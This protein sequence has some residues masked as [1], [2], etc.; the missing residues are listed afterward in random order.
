MLISSSEIQVVTG[1][2]LLYRSAGVK[3][4]CELREIFVVQIDKLFVY[5]IPIT[6][7]YLEK[8]N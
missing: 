8:Y 3:L 7:F 2:A 5:R 4:F 1:R 6:A